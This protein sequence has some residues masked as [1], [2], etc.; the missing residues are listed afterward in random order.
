[1]LR[2]LAPRSRCWPRRIEVVVLQLGKLDLTSGA[3]KPMLTM[4]GAVAEMER[5]LL[6]ERAQSGLARARAEGKVLGRPSKTSDEQ[7]AAI[8]VAHGAGETVSAL[9]RE[10]GI[11]RASILN[12]VG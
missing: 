9:A 11:S 5:D 8:K 3:G 10:Y 4:L 12:I 2:T 1:M 7:R 6:V